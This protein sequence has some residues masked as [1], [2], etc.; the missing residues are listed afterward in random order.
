M[1]LH[2]SLPAF[3]WQ[4]VRWLKEVGT[5]ASVFSGGERENIMRVL[6]M[7]HRPAVFCLGEN[8]FVSVLWF[9]AFFPL[10]VQDISAYLSHLFRNGLNGTKNIKF[11][12]DMSLNATVGQQYLEE[13]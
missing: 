7:K 9:K 10:F 2:F 6:G 4:T 3:T 8:G 5:V 1:K 11:C 12:H 13:I